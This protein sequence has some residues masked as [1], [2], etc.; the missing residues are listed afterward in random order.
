MDL[1]EGWSHVRGGVL[2]VTTPSPTTTSTPKPVTEASKQPKVTATRKMIKPKKPVPKP[3][4]STK[5]ATE[6]PNNKAPPNT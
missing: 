5:S 1:G 3:K 2:N 4:S 6:K